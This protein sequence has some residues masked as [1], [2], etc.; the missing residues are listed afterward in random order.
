MTKM[1]N[2]LL[3]A[4]ATVCVGAMAASAANVVPQYDA[5]RLRGPVGDRLDSMILHHVAA[6]DVD[7]ITTPFA[8]CSERTWKWQSEFWGKWMH[9][10]APYAVYTADQSLRQRIERGVDA[11][12][13]AQEPCGYIGNYPADMR[14]GG[15]WDVWGMKYTMMGLLHYCD[16]ASGDRRDAALAACRRLCDYLIAELGPEGR[17]GVP[18]WRTGNWAGMPSSSVLEPVVWLYRRTSDKRYLDYASYLVKGMTEDLDGPR[19]LDLALRHVPPADRTD[20]DGKKVDRRK[21]YEMM[22]CYQGLVEYAEVTGRRELVDAAVATAEE[23][24]RTEINLAGGAASGELWFHGADKQHLPYR[25]LQETCVTTTWMRL[26]EKLLSVTG[27]PRWAD[28]LEKTF[29]NAYL[30]AMRADGGE[31]AAYTPLSGSRWS[32]HHHCYMHTDC[33][34]ANGPRGFLSFLTAF[35]QASGSTAFLN[36]YASG[37]AK[38]RLPSTG[39]E[40]ALGVYTSYPQTGG[41]RITNMTAEPTEFTLALRIPSWCARADAKV[42]GAPVGIPAAAGSYLKLTRRWMAGNVVELDID[43]PVRMHRLEHYVAFTRGPVLLARDT[44]FADGPIDEVLPWRKPSEG[45]MPL[46]EMTPARV[47]GKEFWMVF[48]ASIRMGSHQENPDAR[49]PSTVRFCDY[50]SA[51]SEWRPQNAYRTWF[52]VEYGSDE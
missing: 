29:Y 4:V 27:E 10:A 18:L 42:N 34:T 39:R 49:T 45:P 24:V 26:L 43:L 46:P 36:L 11:V 30:A 6:T 12:L 51:G 52:Q 1:L 35:L 17:R 40:V 8:S 32:G 22:S 44:R 7:Y 15:G 5:V 9:S 19:L 14:C 38:V 31:F 20:G 2:G 16:V 25:H 21:A 33:C 41:V 37:N 47:P 23:I 50:A 13:A 3:A 48:T 28:E